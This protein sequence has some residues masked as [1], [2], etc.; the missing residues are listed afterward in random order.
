MPPKGA[1]DQAEISD[2]E[3]WS[4]ATMVAGLR[5]RGRLP[6]GSSPVRPGW[7]VP[8]TGNLR[9]RS[10]SA[11]PRP[12]GAGRRLVPG[13][14]PA[15][16]VLLALTLAAYLPALD[17]GFVFDDSVYVTQDARMESAEG[18]RRIWTEV[19]GPEYRHQYYPADV[20][21]LLGPVSV[22]GRAPVR[23]PPGQRPAARAQ[24]GAPVASARR[25]ACPG[26]VA[27]RGDLRRPPRARAV[28]GLDHRAQERLV[29]GVRPVVGP[30]LGQLVRPR[31]WTPQRVG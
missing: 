8:W 20:V 25:L 30:C 3:S 17:A 31:S 14:D 24:R 18:L 27:R 15:V 19:G 22:V 2:G 28:G 9:H 16:C 10:A 23:L 12:G 21:G 11:A 7:A 29:H 5:G 4:R 26:R 1:A 6:R 13:G